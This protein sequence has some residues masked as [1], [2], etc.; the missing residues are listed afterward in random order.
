MDDARPAL[1]ALIGL[2]ATHGLVGMVGLVGLVRLVGMVGL[3]GLVGL[4]YVWI[5]K[6]VEQNVF[7]DDLVCLYLARHLFGD[8]SSRLYGQSMI[9]DQTFF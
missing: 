9:T 3:V 2:V 4:A 6:M 1:V 7:S 8:M 5:A